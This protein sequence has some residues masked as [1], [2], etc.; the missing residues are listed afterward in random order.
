MSANH[1]ETTRM[2]AFS[3]AVIA[4]IMTIMVLELRPPNEMTMEGLYQLIP[5]FLSYILSYAILA[6]YWNNHHHLLHATENITGKMMWA[7]LV[8]LFWLSLIPFS[9]AWVGES[10]GESAPAAFYSVVLLMAAFSY[11]LL[12]KAILKK[13]G[14]SSKV[15]QALRNDHKGNISLV[16]YALA[17]IS[18][19]LNPL[20]SY[21]LI[22]FVA[23]IWFVPDRRLA[24]LFDH[25]DE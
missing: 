3:D 21:G 11:S 8:L 25:R 24:P 7:N 2:E 14:K 4:I 10:H 23:I 5:V 19:F 22:L 20:I 1:S 18:A 6:I 9:T 16:C 17:V 13:E 15:A 12:V